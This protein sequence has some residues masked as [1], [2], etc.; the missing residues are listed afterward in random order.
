[1]IY[2]TL[3][4]TSK[5]RATRIPLKTGGEFKRSERVSITLNDQESSNRFVFLTWDLLW[6]KMKL[7]IP[8][9]ILIPVNRQKLYTY[10]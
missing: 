3:Q 9:S 6:T 8:Y 1:M 10:L 2:K 7:Y 5:D 4:Q